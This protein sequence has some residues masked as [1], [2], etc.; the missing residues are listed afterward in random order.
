VEVCTIA[1]PTGPFRRAIRDGV[2]GR[3]AGTP[4][5]WYHALRELIDDPEVRRRMA[6]AAYLDVLGRF[7]PQ[8]GATRLQSVLEQLSGTERSARAFQLEWLRRRSATPPEFDIPRSSVAFRADRLG[9][10]EV[11]VVIPLY[12]YAHFVEEALESVRAQTVQ[13]LDLVVVDDASTDGSLHVA[14]GWAQRNAGRFNRLLVLRNE[15]NS[16]LARSRNVGFDAAETPFVLPLDADNHLLPNCCA[17]L[18]NALGGSRAGFAYSMLQCFGDA[19]HVL[20]TEPFA[21]MRFA[22]SNY[23]DAMALVAKWCWAKVGGYTHIRYG[24]EDYDFWCKCVEHGL[25]GEQVREILAEYRVHD[26]S[27]LRTSTDRPDNKHDVIRR[28]EDRHEWLTI[29]YRP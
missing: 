24:W 12:N 1:S 17:T 10:A 13:R 8:E 28:L 20:G 7:G 14:T 19:E 25:W 15:V 3:L 11:T 5:E 26:A 9:A 21:P 22:S 18:L 2:T 6:H 23:I 16:G 29:A 4:E 27:M